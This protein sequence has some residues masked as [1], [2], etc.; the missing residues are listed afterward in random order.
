M[1]IM[2]TLQQID[3]ALFDKVFHLGRDNKAMTKGAIAFS[4]SGDGYLQLIIPGIVWL[5]E[6]IL[7]PTYVFALAAAMLVERITY[8]VLKIRL[9]V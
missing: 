4:R 7:A 6:S 1:A 3:L 5:S 9:S 8:F 2:A